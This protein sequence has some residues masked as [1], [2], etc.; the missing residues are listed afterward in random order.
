MNANQKIESS[1][2][3]STP[4]FE[5]IKRSALKYMMSEIKESNYVAFQSD[6]GFLNNDIPF[7]LI[8]V[9]DKDNNFEVCWWLND[10]GSFEI[11]S[12]IKKKI[13]KYWEVHT[14]CDR[15]NM[16]DWR[17]H[18]FKSLINKYSA[19]RIASTMVFKHEFIGHKEIEYEIMNMLKEYGSGDHNPNDAGIWEGKIACLYK[20][21]I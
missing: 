8:V 10:W 16:P 12:P 1:W 5:E 9:R 18:N 11:E 2:E 3:Y 21:H 15:D 14:R 20:E 6:F 4:Y 13:R 7:T 19:F 17:H